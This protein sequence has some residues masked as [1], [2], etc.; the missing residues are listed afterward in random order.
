MKILA[1]RC[2]TI[3]L[4]AAQSIGVE[5]QVAGKR[6]DPYKFNNQTNL[7]M[8]GFTYLRLKPRNVPTGSLVT[9]MMP[10]SNGSLL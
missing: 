4:I 3:R 10:K 7:Q 9:I 6:I 1:H 5:K 2:A 8:A